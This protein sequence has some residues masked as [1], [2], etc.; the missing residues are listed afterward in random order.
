MIKGSFLNGKSTDHDEDKGKLEEI[1]ASTAISCIPI[2]GDLN[3]HD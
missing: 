3:Q 2:G 1:G